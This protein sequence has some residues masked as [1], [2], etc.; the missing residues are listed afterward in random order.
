[1]LIV[2]SNKLHYPTYILQTMSTAHEKINIVKMLQTKP[3]F[4]SQVRHSKAKSK[5]A[6]HKPR[7]SRLACLQKGPVATGHLGQLRQ[8]N[9]Y[10]HAQHLASPDLQPCQLRVYA[11][12]LNHGTSLIIPASAA[13]YPAVPKFLSHIC[14][15]IQ[16]K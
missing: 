12:L 4:F 9:V 2:S 14:S 7:Q 1:M 3:N 5:V 6:L 15:D 13:E 16:L 10:V 8:G 11:G